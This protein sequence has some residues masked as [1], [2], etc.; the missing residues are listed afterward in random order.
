MLFAEGMTEFKRY[1]TIRHLLISGRKRIGLQFLADP[2]MDALIGSLPDL[3]FCEKLSLY[4]I[5][6]AK[7]NLDMLF[8]TFKGVAWI[9][10]Q[11]FFE[12]RKQSGL[13][14][15][16][17]AQYRSRELPKGHVR[18]PK[19]YFDKLEQR[20]YAKRTAQVYVKEFERFLFFH[21]GQD[22]M[23]LNEQ[24]IRA[25]L[26]SLMDKKASDSLLNQAINAI[27]FY[28]E[29]VQG[30]PNRFYMLDRPRRKQHL[31]K[32]VSREHIGRMIRGTNNV[33][34]RCIIALLYSAGLRRGELVNLKLRDIDS[35]RML[36]HVRQAKGNKDRMT[37]LSQNLLTELRRYYKDFRPKEFLFEGPNPGSQYGSTSVLSIVKRAGKKAG[38]PFNITPH[39]LRHSFATHLIEDGVDLRRV[40]ILLGHNS[41]KTTE[42]YTHV[43][44]STYRDV[45]SPFDHLM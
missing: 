17:I 30:M 19:T 34:H 13:E 35:E 11:F 25:Y 3:Q 4:H 26:Q 21:W 14:A 9:N 44:Q 40:Q 37:I 29:V 33:K 1:L 42:I 28:Y 2:T 45:K 23:N 12:N 32:V 24:D 18:A 22:P 7:A 27:K 41:S 16:D 6:N 5:P 36:I 20:R 39:V 10:G 8:K 38:A 15:L 31:P 43:A